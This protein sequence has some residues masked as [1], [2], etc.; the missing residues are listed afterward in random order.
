MRPQRG[1]PARSAQKTKLARLRLDRG[2]F[3][4][5]VADATGISLR[6]YQRLEGNELPR[7]QLWYLVNCAVVLGCSLE[8]LIEDEWLRFH[9]LWYQHWRDGDPR[10]KSALVCRRGAAR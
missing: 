1:D 8:D 6:T 4:D 10:G 5:D 7:P 2:Y 9:E 3:Q